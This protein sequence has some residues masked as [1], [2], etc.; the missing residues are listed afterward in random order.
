MAEFDRYQ[1]MDREEVEE[2]DRQDRYYRRH[3]EVDEAKTKKARVVDWHDM[4]DTLEEA[5]GLIEELQ[6]TLRG[7]DEFADWNLT[8]SDIQAEMEEEFQPLEAQAE[9]EYQADMA[10]LLRDY[11]RSVM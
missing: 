4:H 7:Y 9:A 6:S 2:L 10:D 1:Y 5:I 11:Y 3:G 8:L